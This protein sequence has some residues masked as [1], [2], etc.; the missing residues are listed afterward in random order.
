MRD[1]KVIDSLYQANHRDYHHVSRVER[2]ANAVE[3]TRNEGTGVSIED[4]AKCFRY[5]FDKAEIK[6]LITELSKGKL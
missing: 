1:I 2:F 3:D 4:I 5:Q 6:S